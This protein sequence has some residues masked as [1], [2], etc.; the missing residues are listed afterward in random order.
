MAHVSQT[1]TSTI[2]VNV[3]ISFGVSCRGKHRPYLVLFDLTR[4]KSSGF[5]PSVTLF[6][7]RDPAGQNTRVALPVERG[8]CERWDWRDKCR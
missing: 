6:L 8:F 1:A 7:W 4:M 5:P 2:G 3:Q